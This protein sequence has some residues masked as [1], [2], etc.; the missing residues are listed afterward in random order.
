MC[1]AKP[2]EC[3]PEE[4]RVYWAMAFPVFHILPDQTHDKYSKGMKNMRKKRLSRFV[5]AL[6][7]FS[8]YYHKDLFLP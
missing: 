4:S 8:K 6:T 7:S 1:G 5:K 3:K 2:A